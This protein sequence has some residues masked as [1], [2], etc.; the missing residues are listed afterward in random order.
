MMACLIKKFCF[1]R[2]ATVTMEFAT[3]APL[4]IVLLVLTFEANHYIFLRNKLTNVATN[5]TN[6]SSLP[7]LSRDNLIGILQTTNEITFPVD[8]STK[9]GVVISH[10]HYDDASGNMKISWQEKIGDV[11]SKMGIEGSIP[12]N[13]PN[14]YIVT[15]GKSII[16]GEV[17]YKYEPILKYYLYGAEDMY[18][19]RVVVPQLGTMTRLFGE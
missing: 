1:K 11:D 13:L 15:Q 7:S 10:I 19:T 4:Y 12:L 14:N 16:V 8:F 9:G 5:V 6:V 18:E 2:K 3:M 17:F